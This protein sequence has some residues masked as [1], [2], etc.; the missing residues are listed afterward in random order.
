MW[1]AP[2]AGY[3]IPVKVAC[4]AP[5]FV[6]LPRVTVNVA[7]LSDSCRESLPVAPELLAASATFAQRA[8][9][10]RCWCETE[11]ETNLNQCAKCQS[12]NRPPAP[13]GKKRSPY[14][15]DRLRGAKEARTQIEVLKERSPAI[16]SD[17]PIQP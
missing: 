12:I 1:G 5:H 7:Q 16:F 2:N 4:A 15:A 6:M 11:S 13:S 10:I 14:Q 17:R 3:C 8:L 9:R